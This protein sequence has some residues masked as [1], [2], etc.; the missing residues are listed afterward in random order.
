MKYGLLDS[1][2][3]VIEKTL[4][5]HSE[6]EEAVLFGSR[7]IGSFKEASDVD[8]VLKGKKMDTTLAVSLE[9]YFERE[10]NLPY[11]FD[12]L[13]Y[14]DINNKSLKNHIN[15]YG[16]VIYRKGWKK[17]KLGDI[18]TFK[19]GKERPTIIGNIPVYGGNGILGYTS[20]KN[21]DKETIII[22]RVGAYCGSVYFE[23]RPV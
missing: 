21:Q 18:V 23:N 17:V 4:Q 7:A 14:S 12:V 9:N 3:K 1:Q 13:S 10:T 11:F 8:I 15:K 20:E 6:V 16:I 22:G 5:S 2:L 19:N